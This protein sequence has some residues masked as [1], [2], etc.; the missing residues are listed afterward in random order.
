MK[1]DLILDILGLAHLYGFQELETSISE[2][3]KAVLSVRTVCLIYD[4]ASL[5]QVISLMNE[6][7]SHR[8]GGEDDFLHAYI[9]QLASLSTAALVFMDR[10]AVEVREGVK[11]FFVES[12]LIIGDFLGFESRVLPGDF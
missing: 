3:L 12:V 6:I 5:Y 7:P 11:N 8:D 9:F 2:Y 1:E 4:T 10:H